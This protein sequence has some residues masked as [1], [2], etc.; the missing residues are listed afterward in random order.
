MCLFLSSFQPGITI[1]ED[2]VYKVKCWLLK[3]VIYLA[4]VGKQKGT[5]ENIPEDSDGLL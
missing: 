3:A 5:P 4:R 1:R 2:S